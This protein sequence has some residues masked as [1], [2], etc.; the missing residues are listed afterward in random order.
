M[1]DAVNVACAGNSNSPLPYPPSIFHHSLPTT[2][3]IPAP[4]PLPLPARGPALALTPRASSLDPAPAVAID[5]PAQVE[6]VK[7][8]CLPEQLNYPMLEEYDFKNDTV[9]P[10][11]NIEIK[12]HVKLRPYQE[13]SLSK[14]FG[15]GRARC[16][17]MCVCACAG[18]RPCVRTCVCVSKMF[19][20]GRARCA[21]VCA[22]VRVEG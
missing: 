4:L 18:V 3:F 2:C 7:Q 9:N 15:N 14:M 10:D 6:S 12:P 22:C 8:R 13:K 11:L 1:Y 17:R 21:C 20:N 19:G 5:P 16:A